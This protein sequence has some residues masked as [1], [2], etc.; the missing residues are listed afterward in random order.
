M[1]AIILAGGFG[2][3]L[4]PLTDTVAK[5]MVPVAGKPVLV[6]QIEWLKGHGVDE[7]VLCV[8]HRKETIMDHFGDGAR[9]GVTV[10]YVVEDRPLGTAGAFRNAMATF[11]RDDPFFGLNGDVITDLDPTSLLERL[12]QTGAV[13]AI[14][15]VPLPSPYGEVITDDDGRVTSFVEKPRLMDHWINPG[16]YCLAPTIAAYLPEVGSIE[17]DVFP[18]LAQEGKL[19][20]CKHPDGLWVSIDSPKD[21]E[22][23]AARLQGSPG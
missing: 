21:V 1:R 15:L 8:G 18:V 12:R 20:A 13:A 7:L 2:K 6:H 10:R 4:R 19:M 14:A 16:V 22:E 23:A 9:Y 5:S 11:P 3:R 17:Y